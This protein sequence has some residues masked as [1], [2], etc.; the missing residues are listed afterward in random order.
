MLGQPC[1]ESCLVL[2]RKFRKEAALHCA[3]VPVCGN[4]EFYTVELFHFDVTNL[5]RATFS[6][7]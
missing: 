6:R 2:A 3:L 7:G 1:L 4:W 5:A